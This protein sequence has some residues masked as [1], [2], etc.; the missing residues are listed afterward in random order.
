LASADELKV[1]ALLRAMA[2]PV[3]LTGADGRITYGNPAAAA[4]FRGSGSLVSRLIHELLPFVPPPSPRM[5]N[6]TRWQGRYAAPTGGERHVVVNASTIAEAGDTPRRVYVIQDVTLL[7]ELNEWREQL[8]Y[9]AA[10]E[11]RGPL[12]ILGN[13]LEVL[14]GNGESPEDREKLLDSGERTI[15]RVE[16]LLLDLLSA[17]SIRA[18]RFY[19]NPRPVELRAIAYEA[20]DSVQPYVDARDQVLDVS[21]PDE[22]VLVLADLPHISRVLTNLLSNASKY[23][24]AGG[25]IGLQVALDP[26][27]GVRIVVEDHGHGIAKEEQ[28]RLFERFYRVHAPGEQEGIGLGLAIAKGIVEAHGGQI[29]IDSEVGHGTRAWFTLP[30]AEGGLP[31]D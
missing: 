14:K 17:G 6:G 23:S 21:L 16:H 11:V 12:A 26:E 25:P 5:R 28:A 24:P 29:G 30:I 8:L 1:S 18:G 3:V 2:V 4:L 10:H 31:S 15:K 9:H 13:V 7:A 20:L 22:E 19:I 27:L